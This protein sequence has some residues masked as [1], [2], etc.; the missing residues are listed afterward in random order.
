MKNKDQKEIIEQMMLMDA[1]DIIF[2]AIKSEL[3]DTFFLLK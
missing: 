2:D 1:R 3:N